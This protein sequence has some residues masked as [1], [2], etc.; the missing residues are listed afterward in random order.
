MATKSEISSGLPSYQ[1]CNDGVVDEV[2]GPATLYIAGRFVYSSDPNAPPLYE[3]SHSIGFLSDNDRTVRFEKLDHSVT[4]VDGTPQVITRK[5][6]IFDLK[7]PTAATDPTFEYHA[8]SVTRRTLCSFG[9]SPIKSRGLRSSK[10]FQVQR[11]V[12]GADHK[13]AAK[14]V[15]FSAAPAKDKAVGYE[16]SDAQGSLVAREIETDDMMSLVVRAEMGHLVRDA[17]VASW[18]A[19]IWHDLAKGRLSPKQKW[20][21]GKFSYELR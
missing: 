21:E 12:R 9:L 6:H 8:E 7:H 3:L 10:G 11:A 20:A 16:W 2:L 14:E 13:Y 19:R 17:L 5:R 4:D 1:D 15:L 18:V